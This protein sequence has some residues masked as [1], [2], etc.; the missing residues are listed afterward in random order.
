MTLKAKAK[1]LFLSALKAVANLIRSKLFP[2]AVAKYCKALQ[3]ASEAVIDKA[4]DILDKISKEP[5]DS[6]K[7]IKYT[8]MLLLIKN[9]LS[10]LGEV[11]VATANAIELKVNFDVI[12]NTEAVET[13][14][15]F[16]QEAEQTEDKQYD[17]LIASIE[18]P[19]CDDDGCIVV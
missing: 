2:K 11:M 7:R 17:E 12:E 14:N 8:Y 18:V 4:D 15:E 19:H 1:T 6:K 16:K 13:I 10:S 9:T 3:D 5:E